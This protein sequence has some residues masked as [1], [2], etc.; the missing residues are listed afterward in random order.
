MLYSPCQKHEE[1]IC[2]GSGLKP[3]VIE[4]TSPVK[5]E[6][7]IKTPK[8]LSSLSVYYWSLQETEYCLGRPLID[9]ITAL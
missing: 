6:L 8:P 5:E 4:I 1:N 7:K 9:L 2:I 3:I